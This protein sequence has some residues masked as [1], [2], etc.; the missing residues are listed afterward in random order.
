MQMNNKG[1]E[2]DARK[3]SIFYK[4]YPETTCYKKGQFFTDGHQKNEP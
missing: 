3:K 4:M 2:W 1:K